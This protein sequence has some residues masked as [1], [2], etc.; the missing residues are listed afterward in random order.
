MF[1]ILFGII[2]LIFAGVWSKVIPTEKLPNAAN[3]FGRVAVVFIAVFM[4]GSTSFIYVGSDN[5]GHLKKIYLGDELRPGHIIATD[6]EKGKQAR[7]LRPGF[8]FEPFLRVIYDVDATLP[9]VDIP[10]GMYG[11][12]ETQDGQPLPSGAI[13]AAEWSDDQFADMLDAKK[14]LGY[15]DDDGKWVEG[16]GEKGLQTAILKPGRYPI[17]LYLFKITVGNKVYDEN[18]ITVLETAHD[19]TQRVIPTGFVGVVTSRVS[20][21]GDGCEAIEKTAITKDGNDIPGALSVTLV[22]HGC[23][24]VW[25]D[26][27]KPGGYYLNR[28]AYDVTEVDTRVQAWTYQGGYTA[29]SFNLKVDQEGKIT[30]EPVSHKVLVPEDAADHAVDVK[31]EGWTVYQ[32]LK[33]VVQVTPENAPI[34]VASVGGLQQ[35]EDRVLTPAIYSEIRTV[36]GSQAELPVSKTD[37]TLKLRPVRILDVTENRD[38]LQKAVDAKIRKHGNKAG[39]NVMEVR[40]GNPDIPPEMLVARKREQ[41]A[42]Q[43]KKAY[44]QEKLAQDERVKTEKSRATADQQKQLVTQEINNKRAALKKTELEDLGIGEK[45]RLKEI[46]QGQEAQANVLGKENVMKITILKEVLATLANNPALLTGI[47]L[48]TTVVFGG[49]LE[50][51]AA[52]LKDSFGGSSNTALA[53][54]KK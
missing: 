36:L 51:P 21:R 25:V 9:V 42:T 33:V 29:R 8:K 23:R 30:Q 2:L 28:E 4:F 22:P 5:T 39:V 18:G 35:V 15:K 41:L 7:I 6:G 44:E 46:A 37:L 48:P 31:V 16:R 53:P 17:N 13:M 11:L 24:G 40:F 47:K 34:V 27:L 12:I 14:F 38:Y 54:T 50:G 45:L 20:K 32:N 49:G 43:L 26:A 52:I 1:Q 3:F 10:K 19:T